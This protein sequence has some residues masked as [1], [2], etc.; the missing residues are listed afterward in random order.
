MS[1]ASLP[2]SGCDICRQAKVHTTAVLNCTMTTSSTSETVPKKCNGEQSMLR[3]TLSSASECVRLQFLSVNAVA[4]CPHLIK[5]NGLNLRSAQCFCH[6]PDPLYSENTPKN[7]CLD[8]QPAASAEGVDGL[9]GACSSVRSVCPVG[10]CLC[11]RWLAATMCTQQNNNTCT[12]SSFRLVLGC[13]AHT[14][15]FPG[16]HCK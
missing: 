14:S 11:T 3:A 4:I 10:S 15:S 9:C 6:R 8:Q 1:T 13:F 2:S 16:A 12:R 7:H 5:G